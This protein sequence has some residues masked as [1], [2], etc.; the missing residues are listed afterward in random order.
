M[1]CRGRLSDYLKNDF[2]ELGTI[3]FQVVK[4]AVANSSEMQSNILNVVK[5][6]KST[7]NPD[8]TLLLQQYGIGEL[9]VM[10]ECRIA[11]I[12]VWQKLF[13]THNL[14]SSWDSL[15][16]VTSEEQ[17]KNASMLNEYNE[18]DWLH[19]DQRCANSNL[20]DNIQGYLSLSDGD[21]KS[22]S[23]IFYVYKYGSAQDMIDAFHAKFYTRK[24]RYGRVVHS[25]YDESDFHLFSEEELQWLRDH[26]KLVKP[27]L[28]KG[29]L[30]LWCSAMPHASAPDKTCDLMVNDR[31]GI[32]VSMMPKEYANVQVLH[33]RRELSKQA[34]TSS[35]NV[36][37]PKLFPFSHKKS[38]V[39]KHPIIL[40]KDIAKYR[41]KL[42][43]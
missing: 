8:D 42:I 1:A 34:L 5:M 32:F 26:C 12:P 4:N 18:P 41:K 9:E 38:Q 35:H 3:G 22:H 16:Y 11:T 15:T 10:W 39:R 40:S 24:N 20:V 28:E 43:G 2:E 23:T 30:L 31:V 33:N 13:G 21:A 29:D 17:V 7:Y 36:L 37:D 27:E 14:I 6:V 19:R 25:S